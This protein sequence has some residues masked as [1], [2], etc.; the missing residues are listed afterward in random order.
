VFAPAVPLTL[1]MF[2]LYRVPEPESGV[3][4]FEKADT[5]NVLIGSPPGRTFPDTFQLLAVSPAPDTGGLWKVTTVSSKGSGAN[6]F[7]GG[8]PPPR[9]VQTEKVLYELGPIEMAE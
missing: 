2:R 4:S 5:R 7:D 3:K 8:V 6:Y 9:R 1:V